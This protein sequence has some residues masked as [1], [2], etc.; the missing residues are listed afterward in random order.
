MFEFWCHEDGELMVVN[1]PLCFSCLG[2]IDL[3]W[4]DF[5]DIPRLTCFATSMCLVD[6]FFFY[7][8]CIYPSYVNQ[9]LFHD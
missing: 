7:F 3:D 6:Y 2:Y 8:V 1:T 5:Y 4:Y 9:L